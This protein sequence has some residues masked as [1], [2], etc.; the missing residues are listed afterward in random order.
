MLED[1]KTTAW[2]PTCKG[3]F[4]TSRLAAWNSRTRLRLLP[5]GRGGRISLIDR[6]FNPTDVYARHFAM[7]TVTFGQ[8]DDCD[9]RLEE[10]QW[11]DVEF[12]WSS[13]T[14]GACRLTVGDRVFQLPLVRPSVF[15][16]SY[17]QFQSVTEGY[18]PSGYLVEYVEAK[19]GG[20]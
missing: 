6:W 18:D 1:L 17:I 12:R 15:G 20:D 5:G 8:D 16:I 9:V 7:F 14:D 10:G 11:Y 19:G 4:G 3:L 2:C 13:V